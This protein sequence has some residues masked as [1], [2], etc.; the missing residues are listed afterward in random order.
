MKNIRYIVLAGL[1]LFALLLHLSCEEDDTPPCA[2]QIWYEDLDSDGFGNGNSTVM[3]CEQPLDFVDI[4]GD[5]DDLDGAIHP[6]AIEIQNGKDDNC[7]A[8]TDE[9]ASDS[10][11]TG[12]CFEGFCKQLCTNDGDCPP[13]TTCVDVGNGVTVCQ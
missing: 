2:E 8:A 5:C 3:A 4:P 11:C 9:C 10:D 13:G 7:N 6:G 1:S 12:I